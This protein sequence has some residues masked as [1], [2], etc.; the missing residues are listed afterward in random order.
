MAA[1]L[2]HPLIVGACESLGLSTNSQLTCS[3]FLRRRMV[4]V[5]YRLLAL[6]LIAHSLTAARRFPSDAVRFRSN[7]LV[8]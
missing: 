2:S 4:P 5:R 3:R 6:R 8:S 7:G 1:E